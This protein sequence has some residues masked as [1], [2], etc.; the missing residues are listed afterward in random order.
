MPSGYIYQTYNDDRTRSKK[1][2]MNNNYYNNYDNQEDNNFFDM[3]D[4]RTNMNTV[5]GPT[6]ANS[7]GNNSMNTSSILNHDDSII[8]RTIKG[9]ADKAY[10]LSLKY[11][12][13]D[14]AKL[15]QQ[16][17][18][19]LAKIMNDDEQQMRFNQ[20]RY[21]FDVRAGNKSGNSPSKKNVGNSRNQNQNSKTF[22]GPSQSYGTQNFNKNQ[23]F[24]EKQQKQNKFRT[25][26]QYNG[27][28]QKETL[29]TGATQN[30]S[31]PNMMQIFT[32]QNS[33]SQNNNQ[34]NNM[35]IFNEESQLYGNNPN[36]YIFQQEYTNDQD[37]EYNQNIY[38]QNQSEI[39]LNTAVQ[40][41]FDDATRRKELKERIQL[42]S[43]K[44]E[45][46][47]LRQQPEICKKSQKMVNNSKSNYVPIHERYDKVLQQTQ[48]K[49][50]QFNARIMEESIQKDP[51][52]FF[53]TFHPKTNQTK[54]PQNR[55]FKDL[56]DQLNTWQYGKMYN[57]QNKQAKKEQELEKQCTF[58]PQINQV[59]SEIMSQSDKFKVD[60]FLSRMEKFMDIKEQKIKSIDQLMSKDHTFKPN[61]YS[62]N[63]VASKYY[64]RQ[65]KKQQQ[66]QSERN[67]KN[68]SV[69]QSQR[70]DAKESSSTSIKNSKQQSVNQSAQS[71]NRS[72]QDSSAQNDSNFSRDSR[73]YQNNSMNQHSQQIQQPIQQQFS[74]QNSLNH[75][76]N[77]TQNLQ[78]GQIVNNAMNTNAQKFA[79]VSTH[80]SQQNNQI[81][82]SMTPSFNL[83]VVDSHRPSQRGAEIQV[84]SRVAMNNQNL[85]QQKQ[86]HVQNANQI[87]DQ[88]FAGEMSQLINQSIDSQE[89]Y[90]ND[91]SSREIVMNPYK[92]QQFL[93][94][95]YDDQDSFR[96]DG[97]RERNQHFTNVRSDDRL[98]Q[99]TNSL[100]KKHEDSSSNL[101]NNQNWIFQSNNQNTQGS[102]SNQNS[103]IGMQAQNQSSVQPFNNHSSI[104]QE[105]NQ[106]HNP[107]F[108]QDFQIQLRQTLYQNFSKE[109]QN[110]QI[111]IQGYLRDLEN[112]MRL[113]EQEL[114]K[115]EKQAILSSQSSQQQFVNIN[116][117]F[118]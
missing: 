106:H 29:I 100:G 65:L 84:Q 109:A 67:S 85:H 118:A 96:Q 110:K 63:N 82:K 105:S 103:I 70:I 50:E 55:D 10:E 77:Q 34:N 40:R 35:I 27:G 43:A 44:R 3:G 64:E 30:G 114:D 13:Q 54:G 9:L 7:N 22:Q 6:T 60:D 98:T 80:G 12:L 68:Q 49:K 45:L 94:Q 78:N 4:D 56:V 36:S 83:S 2:Q 75:P 38:D 8:S 32:T 28:G 39:V 111:D 52:E 91:S 51:D 47:E 5:A 21:E 92:N 86:L 11:D 16:E 117:T 62:T 19:R 108:M 66:Q 112:K 24:N 61:T 107:H 101:S 46:E 93:D 1:S 58:K 74:S 87:I 48:D 15:I 116:D 89:V 72:I 17:E 88:S 42:L 53:P 26:Q 115:Y 102:I 33:S 79:S 23:D 25:N 113:D 14:E 99:I 41:L 104:S 69:N 31:I 73:Q 90:L 81:D 95:D 37:E 59:S 20:Q 57:Q 97:P 76:F 18:K 71:I